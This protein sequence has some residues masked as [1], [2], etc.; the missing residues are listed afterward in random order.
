MYLTGFADEAADDIDGQLRAIKK[1]GWKNM[2]CRNVSGK[3]LTDITDAQFD[4]VCAKCE[5]A[6]ISIN[7]FGSAIGNWAKK[8]SDSPQ[9]SY[10]EFK[11]AIPRMH[12]LKTGMI[13]VMS[14]A[15][16]E[17]D[18]VNDPSMTKEVIARMKVLARMAEDGG[19]VLVHENCNNWGGRSYEHT[20]RLIDE[21]RSPNFKLVFD[22]GNPVTQLDIRGKSPF[23]Y[24][25]SME[26]Y[27]KVKASVIYVHIKDGRVDKGKVVYTFPGE[28]NGQVKEIVKDLLTSG[29]D[30]GFSIE[31]HLAV[32]QH[33]STVKS[34]A[35]ARFDNFV[36]YGIRMEKILAS[37]RGA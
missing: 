19:V 3:N 11:R 37:I 1:L 17:D 13:R 14:F 10:D 2:E 30:G 34:T 18:S 36:E 6:G 20:L 16:P 4:E 28:G 7:C 33:D 23:K 26:F 29:Y 21:I 12:R 31:P 25:D 5:Q 27:R 24:Q 8:I 32:V 22:T 15:V 35:Q 9:S